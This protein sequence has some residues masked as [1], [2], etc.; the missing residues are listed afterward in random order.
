MNFQTRV[1]HELAT[2]KAMHHPYNSCHEAFAV[3]LE[4]V[5]EFWD[6]VKLPK[7]RRSSLRL[8][9]ELVQIA[10][11]AQRAAEDLDLIFQAEREAKGGEA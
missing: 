1:A 6:E 9:A 8:L 7:N 2:A 4:E 11:T 10:T 3:I 5:E